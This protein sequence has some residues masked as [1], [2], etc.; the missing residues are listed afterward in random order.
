[1]VVANPSIDYTPRETANRLIFRCHAPEVLISGPAGTGK[2]LACLWKLHQCAGEVA[3]LRALILRKTRESLTDSALV[4]FERDVLPEG[5]PML[6]GARR[7]SRK[8]YAYPN[9][10]EIV[11][12]GF[13]QSSRD[14]SAKVMSTDWDLIF[15]Q[16]SIEL[17]E[18][19]WERLTT[20]LR[21]GKL[22]YQQLIGDTNPDK[23]SHW[24]KKRCDSGKTLLLESRHEDNPRLWD[25]P[26]QC[27]TPEGEAYIAKLDA[28]SGPR[29]ERLRFGRWTQAE[30]L[31]YSDW[32]PAVHVVERREIP[33]TWPRYLAVDFGYTS[34]FICQW[35]AED[36]DGRLWLYR[37]IVHTHRL[38]EDHA[39]QILALSAG[40]PTPVALICD[41]D[42]EAG[43][44]PGL[45][46]VASHEGQAVGLS[47]G[48]GPAQTAGRWQAA[49]VRAAGRGRGARPGDGRKEAADRIRAGNRRLHLEYGHGQKEGGRSRGQG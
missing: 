49:A 7:D 27:W 1:M 10:S 38:V 31:V 44:A 12:A 5:C 45:G 25:A 32:D 33:V 39:R 8:R 24:L 14:V 11:V 47:S 40:E 3:G 9:G 23:P 43:A 42:L 13:R 4:T 17:G 41:H 22:P 48:D 20:R 46:D 35:W 21:N 37:E 26:A 15:V 18:E 19:E 36:N 6:A 29:K 30:G 16:E 28:L 34:A 2:S